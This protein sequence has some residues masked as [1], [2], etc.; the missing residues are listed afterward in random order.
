MRNDKVFSRS[1]LSGILHLFCGI[2]VGTAV[3][4]HLCS[5]VPEAVHSLWVLVA[6]IA[7][8]YV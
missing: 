5:A 8:L 1:I 7:N 2:E 6:P 3:L 4:S